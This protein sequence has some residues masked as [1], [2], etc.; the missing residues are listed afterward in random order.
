M[1]PQV[2]N[3]GAALL[4][5]VTGCAANS[6]PASDPVRAI[7]SVKHHGQW[8]IL[9]GT[10]SGQLRWQL[11]SD[12][13]VV[14][15]VFGFNALT[16][17]VPYRDSSV[18]GGTFGVVVVDGDHKT[19]TLR[20]SSASE[21]VTDLGLMGDGTLAVGIGD[22]CPDPEASAG[23]VY[24][25]QD[26]WRAGRRAVVQAASRIEGTKSDVNRI[27]CLEDAICFGTL[28]CRVGMWRNG[29]AW[30]TSVSGQVFSLAAQADILVG[31]RDGRLTALS[32]ETGQILWAISAHSG[33][34]SSICVTGNRVYTAGE[35]GKIRC[36][37]LSRRMSMGEIFCERSL[38]CMAISRDGKKLLTGHR[39]GAVREWPI[40]GLGDVD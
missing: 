10:Q 34:L 24:L 5:M 20:H 1:R 16:D 17:V 21:L 15:E 14:D 19:R 23:G 27:L 9:S 13:S 36:W 30:V 18:A 37:D 29:V 28:D 35:E 38:T 22:D 6:A 33:A 32:R 3:A 39:S 7:V 25:V 26:H 11:E 4:V 2:L 31:T 40:F 8:C 12:L